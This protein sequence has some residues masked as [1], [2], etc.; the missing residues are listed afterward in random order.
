[1]QH[2]QATSRT[3][4]LLLQNLSSRRRKFGSLARRIFGLEVIAHLLHCDPFN[5]LVLVDM[6]DDSVHSQ[7][8]N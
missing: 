4:A 5:A 3:G 2:H 1:M 7:F 8:P 6:F